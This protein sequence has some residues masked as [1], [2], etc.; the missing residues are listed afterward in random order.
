MGFCFGQP[1]AANAARI[2]GPMSWDSGSKFQQATPYSLGLRGSRFSPFRA[3]FSTNVSLCQKALQ[4]I[5]KVQKED[6]LK[7][8]VRCFSHRKFCR[9]FPI[10]DDG[11]ETGNI[12]GPQCYDWST[13]GK[14]QGWLGSGAQ[15]FLGWL[16]ERRVIQEKW[17]IIEN[18]IQFPQTAVLQALG[19]LYHVESIKFAPTDMAYPTQRRRHYMVLILKAAMRWKESVVEE[20]LQSVFFKTFCEDTPEVVP[21]D[22]MMRAPLT[23]WKHGKKGKH[24]EEACQA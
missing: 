19:D 16:A 11:R 23:K 14:K 8:K 10:D 24:F 20:G 22:C 12:S 1:R 15:L 18:V 2:P 9:A 13:M 3:P 7:V 4:S 6:L 21:G 17:I 5:D